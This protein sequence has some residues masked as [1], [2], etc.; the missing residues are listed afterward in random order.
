MKVMVE[1]YFLSEYISAIDE[2]T[3]EILLDNYI[4]LNNN[5]SVK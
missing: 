4:E 3:R 5:F 1:D 2:K